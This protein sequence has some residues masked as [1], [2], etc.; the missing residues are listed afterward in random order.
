MTNWTHMNLAMFLSAYRDYPDWQSQL[1]QQI[2]KLHE[3]L[4]ENHLYA[5]PDLAEMIQIT[6]DFVLRTDDL[7]P[8]GQELFLG[9][10]N[11]FERWL[12]AND[13]PERPLSMKSLENALKKIQARHK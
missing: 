8:D 6:D 1:R 7:T 9:P 4:S 2:Q 11:A 5:N 3:F 10:R 12:R 13:N